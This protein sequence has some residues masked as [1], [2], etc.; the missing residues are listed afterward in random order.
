MRLTA[1]AGVAA[2][3]AAAP[4]FAQAA[5]R[6]GD[7]AFRATYKELVETNTTLSAGSCT[8]AA[9]RMAARLSAAGFPQSDLHLVVEPSHPKEGNLVAVFPGTDPKAKAILLLAHID[10]VEANRDDWARDPFTLV[11]ENGFLYARGTSDDK[12]QAAIWVD[13]LARFKREGFRPRRTIKMALTC[14]EETAGAFNGA[15]YLAAE[16]RDLIDAEFALNEGAGGLLDETGK[17]VV[18]NIQAGEKFPQNYRLEVTNPGG[19]SSRPVRENAIYRL[20]DALVKLRAHDF[21]VQSNEA[22]RGYF[23]AMAKLLPG[24]SSAAMAAFAADPSDSGAAA[25][26]AAA[27]PAWNAILRTTCVA[28]L[29]EGGH[30]TNALPQRARANVN[31]RIFPGTSV[32]QVRQA[33]EQV[34]ADPQ[35]KISTLE[36]RSRISPPPPLTERVLGPARKVAAEVF[37]GV[38][39]VPLMA[40]GG[41]DGAFLTPAGIPTYGLTGIFSD[42]EGSHAH[43]LDERIRL[44]SLLDGREFL[45]RLVKAYSK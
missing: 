42:K 4:V 23:G 38:P 6:G 34:V 1:I 26:L 16:K 10:V 21:P 13:T 28:T 30:A 2:L 35:V 40:A 11:E 36:T 45:Y 44:K 19:H 41:T 9:E 5:D 25:T 37:P 32:E 7:S 24:P 43:G 31:C 22:T 29:L 3:M 20:A 18:L 33:L 15:Q 14:G 17:R 27:D 12:A 39:L 8:L